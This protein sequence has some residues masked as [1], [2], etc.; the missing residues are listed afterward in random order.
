MNPKAKP[1]KTSTVAVTAPSSGGKGTALEREARLLA[2]TTEAMRQVWAVAQLELE[3]IH[4]PKK[5]RVTPSLK[6]T[7]HHDEDGN[8]TGHLALF[9]NFGDDASP[10][11]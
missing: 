1:S 4:P 11:C 5:G 6:A 3:R 8:Y 9:V 7:A 10:C 2:S